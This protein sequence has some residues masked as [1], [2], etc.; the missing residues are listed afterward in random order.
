MLRKLT[1]SRLLSSVV[2]GAGLLGFA[3]IAGVADTNVTYNGCENLYT[4]IIRLLPSSLPAPYNT[5]CNTTTTNKLLKEVAITWNQVGSQGPQGIQGKQGIQGLPGTNGSNGSN[6]TNGINGKDGVGVTAVALAP[7]DAN[8]PTGGSAFTSASGITYACNG[9][10]G[11]N[12]T[13]GTNGKDGAQGLPG[14]QGQPGSALGSIDALAGLPCGTGSNAGTISITYAASPP[15]AVSLVCIPGKETLTLTIS[16]PASGSGS[17]T[18][19]PAGINCSSSCT[20]DFSTGATVTLTA[21]DGPQNTH[22]TQWGGA[23]SGISPTCT[24]TMNAATSVTALFQTLQP[25]GINNTF[26]SAAS[27]G[28]TWVCGESSQLIGTTFPAGTEDWYTF[29]FSGSCEAQLT[30]IAQ[31]GIRFDVYSGAPGTPGTDVVLGVVTRTVLTIGG[32]YWIR[33]YGD[34]STVTGD[35]TLQIVVG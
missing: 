13:N 16:N 29:P 35:W 17:V 10:P 30:L 2:I 11:V 4:G 32:N 9:A 31:S 34:T 6:G 24:V 5:T 28:S 1:H 21:T 12:G 33:V 8:C 23:C 3:G 19:S 27:T 18:S 15:G 25:D 26:T 7:G 14:I 20:G 22:F